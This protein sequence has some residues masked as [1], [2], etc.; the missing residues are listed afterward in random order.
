[1]LKMFYYE[2]NNLFSFSTWIFSR[3]PKLHKFWSGLLIFSLPNP[4]SA[5]F[6]VQAKI[7]KTLNTAFHI[8]FLTSSHSHCL[9][10]TVPAI[11][12]PF[13]T[14]Q[15]SWLQAYSCLKALVLAILNA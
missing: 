11:L 10:L 14:A 5:H 1:M 4:K 15:H 7:L 6:R 8:T 3:S 2:Y 9:L 13:F 12:T